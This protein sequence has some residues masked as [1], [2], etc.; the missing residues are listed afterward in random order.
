MLPT[1]YFFSVMPNVLRMSGIIENGAR[2]G[3]QA[4][5][6]LGAC[7]GG[8]VVVRLGSYR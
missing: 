3:D 1:R 6:L 4:V 5:V 7:V 8:S 2:D